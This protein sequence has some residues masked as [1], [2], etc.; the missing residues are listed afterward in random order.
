MEP[1]TASER[2]ALNKRCLALEPSTGPGYFAG[3]DPEHCIESA[4]SVI[5]IENKA[6]KKMPEQPP[7][8]V[9]TRVRISECYRMLVKLSASKMFAR[10]HP[11]RDWALT[12]LRRGESIFIVSGDE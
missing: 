9:H 2:E 1:V 6:P 12:A 3:Y 5:C 8:S 10:Q 4:T 7:P 11:G